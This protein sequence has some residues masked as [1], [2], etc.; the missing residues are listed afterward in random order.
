LHHLMF[1][2]SNVFY[3]KLVDSQRDVNKSYKT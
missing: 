2:M 3:V 1:G